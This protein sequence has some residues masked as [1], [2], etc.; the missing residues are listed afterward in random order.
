MSARTWG[1]AACAMAVCLS[2]VACGTPKKTPSDDVMQGTGATSGAD[3]AATTVADT[4][5]TTAAGPS[6]IKMTYI[7]PKEQAGAKSDT[8]LYVKD[9]GAVGDGVTDDGPAISDAVNAAV[10]AQATLEFETGRTYYVGSS[11]NFSGYFTTPFVFDGADGVT[12]K[13]NG[14]T[15]KVAPGINYW[16]YWNSRDIRME[17]LIF[18]YAV[19]VYL[20]GTVIAKDENTVTFETDTEPYTDVYDYSDLV[21]FSI[22][23]NEGVQ[24]RPHMFLN[25]MERTGERRV[26]VSYNECAYEIGDTVFLPN[27]GIGHVFPEVVYMGNGSGAHVIDNVIIKAAP[28]FVMAI[29]GNNSEF[30]FENVDFVTDDNDGRSVHM[31]A[32]RDGYHCKDNRYPMH[33][34]ECDVGVLFDDV[35]NLSGTMSHIS[36]VHSDSVITISYTGFETRE[37]D[38]VDVYDQREGTF[39]GTATVVGAD[40]LTLTLDTPLL[41]P[42]VGYAVA[43]RSICCP[44]S[45]IRNSRFTGTYRFRR[46]VMA[47][48]CVFELL[49]MWILEDGGVEGPMPSN[50]DFVNCTFIGK[51]NIEIGACNYASGKQFRDVG[52]QMK[53][54]GFF[55]CDLGE[56]TI[57]EGRRIDV[58]VMDSFT[59]DDLFTYVPSDCEQK[60]R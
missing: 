49:A 57:V 43:N 32:W 1:V 34:N 14:A 5:A 12:I 40:G 33:W 58:T 44:G 26:K 24:A 41:E 29:K 36:E 39:C 35:F 50:I 30:Y 7:Y 15:V 46:E 53:G 19:P 27:P 47:E 2:L 6:E 4:E 20:V 45:T 51:G 59:V 55:G 21:A 37:G 23:Y 52:K 25:K 60:R 48:N 8:V 17:N 31:V 10:A 38:V 28:S 54:F 13:G 42:Q 16:V 11:K 56:I 18:D 3:T 22:E 9:F